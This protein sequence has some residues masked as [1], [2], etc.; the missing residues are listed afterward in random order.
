M[1]PVSQGSVG[2]AL[3]ASAADRQRVLAA[4]A[5]GSLAGMAPDLDVLIRSSTDPLLFLEYHRQFTHALA[6]APV[7]ALLCALVAYPVARRWLTWRQVYGFCLLG[8]ASHGLLDACTSYGTQLW[9]P[10]SDYRVAWNAVSVVDP[11]VTLPLLAALVLSAVLRSA[12]PSRVGL[13]WLVLYLLFGLAQGQRAQDAAVALAIARGHEPADLLVKPSFGNVLAWKS[14]YADGGWYYVDA[15]RAGVDL[16]Y[17]PGG[18]IR[19]LDLSRDLAWLEPG[20]TQATDVARFS[21]FSEGYL[22]LQPADGDRVIDMRYSLLP[23]SIDALWGIELERDTPD[24]HVRFITDRATTPAE[25][26]ALLQM[27]WQPG[28]P[29][30]AAARFRAAAR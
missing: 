5:L 23:N 1:D 29:L 10:F 9:W 2:A 12:G 20:S 3:A 22:A 15:V 21:R 25:R 19:R 30:E 17:Y 4:G 18:R 16:S 27:L 8:Y 26:Q 28:L 7:G 11:L 6:F 24:R 14:V 13:G